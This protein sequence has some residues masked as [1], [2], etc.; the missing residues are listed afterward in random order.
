[1]IGL[2]EAPGFYGRNG[3][4][5]DARN[6][7]YGVCRIIENGDSLCRL[8]GHGR[9]ITRT[10]SVAN[11]RFAIQLA[12]LL[13]EF[14]RLLFHAFAER[15]LFIHALLRGEVAHVLRN[16]HR[17]EARAAHRAEVRDLAGFLGHG[18]VVEFARLVRIEVEQVELVSSLLSIV[19]AKFNAS[20]ILF[21]QSLFDFCPVFQQDVEHNCF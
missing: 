9:M 4:I 17:A 6:L 16:L 12:A 19:V 11:L 2:T 20:E 5:E 21:Y 1:M 18:F 13:H 10:A 8:I 14:H 3:Q 7:T 15:R